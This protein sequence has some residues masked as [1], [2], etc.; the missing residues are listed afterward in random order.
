MQA[1][2]DSKEK[3]GNDEEVATKKND[4]DAD[5]VVV[6]VAVVVDGGGGGGDSKEKTKAFSSSMLLHLHLLQQVRHKV[7][8]WYDESVS[9]ERTRFKLGTRRF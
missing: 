6:I 9:V 8:C 7:K 2:W 1:A 5:G 3:V 4:D